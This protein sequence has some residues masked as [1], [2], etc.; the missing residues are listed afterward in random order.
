MN[1]T[2]VA[3]SPMPTQPPIPLR[4]RPARLRALPQFTCIV[5]WIASAVLH[6]RGE[7]VQ[8]LSIATIPPALRDQVEEETLRTLG[9]LDPIAERVARRRA[10][11]LVA[12]QLT[13]LLA[14]AT[15]ADLRDPVY[16]QDRSAVIADLV[17]G[18]YR[19]Q[20]IYG[21]VDGAPGDR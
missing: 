6:A 5:A 20:L 4:S 14:H 1:R 12:E 16:L 7:D 3:F 13:A 21:G 11:Q 17:L 2:I 15:Q 19:N 18:R 9:V 8:A 10:Q